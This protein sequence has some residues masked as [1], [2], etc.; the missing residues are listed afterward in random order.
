MASDATVDQLKEQLKKSEAGRA[1]LRE[2]LVR[3][4]MSCR[5]SIA[6]TWHGMSR[7]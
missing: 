3:L 7:W 1:K 5:I 6:V 2:S 4:L